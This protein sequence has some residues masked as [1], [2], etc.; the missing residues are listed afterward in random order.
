[1]KNKYGYTPEEYYQE[2]CKSQYSERPYEKRDLGEEMTLINITMNGYWKP[3]LIMNHA[4]KCAYIF[5][6]ANYRLQTVTHDDI[7][8]ESLKGLPEYAINVA[9]NLD[10]GYPSYIYSFHDGIATVRW[11]LNPD[12]RYYMDEDGYGMTDDEEIN[13]Y[14]FIDKECRV[15][16]PFRLVESSSEIDQLHKQAVR[17]LKHQK[18]SNSFISKVLRFFQKE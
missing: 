1:M 2:L 16:L 17:A 13:I 8:W 15:M 6:D 10:F 4:T 11:Q 3:C 7:D 14:G 5:M 18:K 12:G 9:R